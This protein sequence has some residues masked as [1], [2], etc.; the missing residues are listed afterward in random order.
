MERFTL[1]CRAGCLGQPRALETCRWEQVQGKVLV[2][3]RPLVV[4]RSSPGTQLTLSTYI[5]K[6]Y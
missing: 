1:S 6:K 4:L 2:S 5:L 3:G